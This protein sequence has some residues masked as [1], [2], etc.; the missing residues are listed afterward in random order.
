M[1]E[2]NARVH[3]VLQRLCSV[4]PNA[5]FEERGIAE[6]FPARPKNTKASSRIE[7]MRRTIRGL[8]SPANRT[9]IG[10]KG[11]G[12]FLIRLSWLLR[13][14][15]PQP[16]CIR[17]RWFRHQCG[18]DS[19]YETVASASI[20]NYVS[21]ITHHR[22]SEHRA[23]GRCAGFAWGLPDLRSFLFSARARK[24]QHSPRLGI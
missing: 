19:R 16:L 6:Q 2:V 18:T 5:I 8:M 17:L 11:S 24:P 1:I 23:P 14:R 9:G 22:D 7:G 15:Y 3:D 10:T 13:A 4:C 12:W 20:S 21:G